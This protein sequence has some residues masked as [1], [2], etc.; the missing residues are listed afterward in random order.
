MSSAA[1]RRRPLLGGLLLVAA[2]VVVATGCAA[3]PAYR[4]PSLPTHKDGAAHFIVF[5]VGQA[6][7]MLVLYRG[8]TLLVDAG[9]ARDRRAR[10]N[11]RD[12][13]RRLEAITGRRH[14]DY[15]VITH[16]HA[17]H[18]GIHGRGRSASLGE[19]GLWGLLADERVTVGTL[20]DRGS[21]VIGPKG[22]TQRAYE[23]SLP[24]WL[25]ERVRHRQVAREG[26]LIEMGPGFKI[27]VVAVNGAGR[28]I[29]IHEEKGGFFKQY[30]PSENDYSIALKFTLGDFELFSGGDLTGAD[31]ARRFG[32]STT[33]YNDIETRVAGRVGDVEVYRV[34]HHGSDHSSN[35]CFIRVLNP[36][37]SIFSVGDNGYGHPAPRVYQA[38]RKVSRVIL[39]GGADKRVY[40][41]VKQ[42]IAHHEVEVLVEPDGKHYY[43]EGAR[44]RALTEEEERA[45]QDYLAA[46]EEKARPTEEA[47]PSGGHEPED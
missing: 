28:L 8:K 47:G 40:P 18:V 20:I 32:N 22:S 1:P 11:F 25:R 5:D 23:R 33:S 35:P 4:F 21:F 27:E 2:L 30:P 16:Y 12:I 44:Y 7:A 29:A 6:D 10:Q 43:V 14:L 17:D 46:C 42:D 37:V 36:E 45:R 26:L 15:V 39:T 3:L 9:V 13:P 34:S 19:L 31:M 38:L 41:M 24:H